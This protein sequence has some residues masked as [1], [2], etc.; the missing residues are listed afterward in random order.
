MAREGS[1]ECPVCGYRLKG[2]RFVGYHCLKCHSHFSA[3]FIA[4]VQRHHFKELIS[5]HF[6]RPS[7]YVPP[8]PNGQHVALEKN[9]EV[10]KVLKESRIAVIKTQ[11]RLARVLDRAER[12]QKQRM[13]RVLQPLTI[14]KPKII[15]KPKKAKLIKT[16]V[17]RPKAKLKVKQS[18]RKMK[19]AR[20]P[21]RRR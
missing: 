2:T 21:K 17:A 14:L 3:R 6:A 20:K 15:T 10:H 19:S 4:H 9:P 16:K 1:I 18:I 5:H 7:I 11:E 8:T 13:K 12:S